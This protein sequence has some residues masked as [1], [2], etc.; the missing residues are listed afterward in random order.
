VSLEVLSEQKQ[1]KSMALFFPGK[2]ECGICGKVIEA[3]DALTMFP[4]FLG[5]NHPL[6]RYSDCAFHKSCFEASPDREE[7]ERL[8]ARHRYIWDHRPSN[9][10]WEEV[11]AWGKSA[12]SEFD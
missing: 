1:N 9:L 8:Y 11:E 10:T 6:H 5:R 4:S 12:F 2:S 3:A 7:V